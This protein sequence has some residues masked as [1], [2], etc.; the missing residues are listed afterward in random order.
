[1][2]TM[3]DELSSKILEVSRWKVL[4]MEYLWSRGAVMKDCL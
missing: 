4:V 1:V 3:Q 2:R